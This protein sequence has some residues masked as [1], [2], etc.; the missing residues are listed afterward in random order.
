MKN[1]IRSFV[2][3][4]WGNDVGNWKGENVEGKYNLICLKLIIFKFI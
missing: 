4:G 3:I 1:F 2:R